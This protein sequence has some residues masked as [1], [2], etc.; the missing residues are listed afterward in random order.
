MEFFTSYMMRLIFHQ[1]QPLSERQMMTKDEALKLALEALELALSSH[2]VMLLSDP[3]QDPWKTKGVESKSRQ[4][5]T[6]IKEALAQPAQEPM[7]TY[8]DLWNALQK[9]DTYAVFLPTF[10]VVKEGGLDA[11]VENIVLA[12][13][14]LTQ[15]AQ[16]PVAMRYDYDGYGYKYID[17][18]S[19]SDW[20][21]RIKDAEPLYATPPDPQPAQEP[22]LDQGP[23]Y[24]RGFVDGRLYQTKTSV[25]KAVNAIA[26]PAQ[27]PVGDI[28]LWTVK[29]GLKNNEFDYYGDLPEGTH[30]LYTTPPQRPWVGLM[31][32][33]RVEGD[34]VIISVKG[35]NDAARELCGALIKEIEA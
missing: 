24:E 2:G 8:E 31:R 32:G 9:I 10:E 18:G 14:K 1:H 7:E 23:D 29:G 27:K 28:T 30:L 25:D 26:Q 22:R 21:T 13:Q 6:A 12:M 15:P 3:P 19:G 17:S 20:Q 35:G 16:E 33:V 34:T 11:V 5:I 4:A